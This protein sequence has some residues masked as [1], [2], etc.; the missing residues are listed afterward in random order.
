MLIRGGVWTLM[1]F[2]IADTFTTNHAGLTGEVV[3]EGA[4][5]KAEARWARNSDASRPFEKPKSGRIAVKVVIHLGDDVMNA[6]K[7]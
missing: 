5:I 1:D 7:I 2:R 4:G 6:L 3:G